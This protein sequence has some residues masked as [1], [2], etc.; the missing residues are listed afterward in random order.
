MLFKEG[1]I[2]ATHTGALNKTQLT[3]FMIT[4]FKIQLENKA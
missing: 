2:V 1:Q 3:A 4:I